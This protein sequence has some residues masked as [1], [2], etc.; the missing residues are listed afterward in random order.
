MHE[1][2]V[3]TPY[4]PDRAAW[5][6]VA[7]YTYRASGH[8]LVLF[9]AGPTA[10]EIE[11]AARG[12]SEFAVYAEGDL[13]LLLY[14]FGRPGRGIPWSDAPSSWHLVPE[15]ERALPPPAGV[16]E[17]HALLTVTLVD[18]ATGIIRALR[19]VTLPP[20]LTA[21]LHLAIRDQAERPWPGGDAY[22]AALAGLYRR[23][24]TTE[25]LLR[26]ARSRSRGGA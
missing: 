11:A 17:P 5:P 3:G 6:E 18:A 24:P 8:E 10:D 15:A 7:Q 2:R 14:R 22:D 20:A 26:V 13:L 21:A 12:T 1:Y 19:A 4:H 9:L 25:A 23:Y 16:A